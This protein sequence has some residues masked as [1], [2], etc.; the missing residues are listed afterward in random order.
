M[1]FLQHTARGAAEMSRP[2][3]LDVRLQSKRAPDRA[4]ERLAA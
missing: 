1:L 4:A 3:I 2:N